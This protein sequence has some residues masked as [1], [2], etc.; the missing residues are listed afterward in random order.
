MASGDTL[1]THLARASSPP[2]SNAAPM[3]RR[4][5]IDLLSI[6]VGEA[7]LFLFGMPRHYAGGGVTLTF[8]LMTAAAATGNV[9]LGAQ[10]SRLDGVDIDDYTFADLKTTADVAVP[11]SGSGVEFQTPLIVA[12][13]SEMDGIVGGSLGVLRVSRE[14]ATTDEAVGDL[15]LIAVEMRET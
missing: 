10:F 11:T 14:A 13:G 1:Y 8:R 12:N 6:D 3:G 15:Q 2:S 7:T 4:N 5:G 9:K